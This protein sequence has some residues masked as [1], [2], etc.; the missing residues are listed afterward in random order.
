MGPHLKPHICNV[1]QVV[2]ELVNENSQYEQAQLF[3]NII[4]PLETTNFF[5]FFSLRILPLSIG[6]PPG[7]WPGI[8]LERCAG[9][10]TGTGT[11][12]GTGAGQKCVLQALDVTGRWCGRQPAAGRPCRRH[13]M[14]RVWTPPPHDTEHWDTEGETIQRVANIFLSVRFIDE[15]NVYSPRILQLNDYSDLNL[16]AGER[17]VCLSGLKGPLQWF[18]D[19]TSFSKSFWESS[20]Q[21]VMN[22]YLPDHNEFHVCSR[23][24]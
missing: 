7:I 2:H 5:F 13:W 14:V 4:A 15:T 19:L 17:S 24:G 23:P 8:R 11:G 9:P 22:D 18:N 6:P 12:A 16:A 1:T 21:K 10:G 3:G 20:S